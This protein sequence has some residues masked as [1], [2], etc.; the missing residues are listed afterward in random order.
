MLDISLKVKIPVHAFK[1]LTKDDLDLLAQEAS[2]III[3]RVRR[4]FMAQE[5]PDGSKWPVSK[6]AILRSEGKKTKGTDGN[7][8]SGGFTL[9]CSGRL[10]HSI[11][12]IKKGVGVYSV[13]TDVP[14]A[15]Y[16]HNSKRPVMAGRFIMGVNS[17]DI[18]LVNKAI[19]KMVK[20]RIAKK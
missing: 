17:E 13:Q 2:T 8:Y 1:F 18:D 9:F 20:D 10:Y 16:V 11:Q 3:S 7:K 4:R 12:Q 14:E 15:L 5:N 6:A 19:S